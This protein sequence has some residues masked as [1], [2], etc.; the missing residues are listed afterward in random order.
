[1]SYLQNGDNGHI[2]GN[3]GQEESNG[4]DG[5]IRDTNPRGT[6]RARR[7]GGYG[8]LM[9]DDL[10]LPGDHD[11]PI[12]LRQRGS[13]GASNGLHAR[14]SPGRRGI[15]HD[16]RKQSKERDGSSTSNARTFGNGLGGSQIQ[17]QINSVVDTA[18]RDKLSC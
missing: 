12:Q 4:S 14:G 18:R 5:N 11:G 17:G 3:H 7:A 16:G 13:E 1:M 6:G 2:N 9:S 10:P 15:G 8:G